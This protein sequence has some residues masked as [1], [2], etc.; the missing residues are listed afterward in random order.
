MK[1]FAI[2]V[3][4][5]VTLGFLG[6]EENGP[7]PGT[8]DEDTYIN[9]LVELQLF[10]AYLESTP[11]DSTKLDSLRGEIFAKYNVS[12]EVFRES[13]EYYQDQYI[14]QKERINKAMERLR[15]DQVRS[16]S[17]EAARSN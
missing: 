16:D 14:E 17:A 4:L 7:P 9:L 10:R 11:V 5:A 6:C 1:A 13:H 12:P 15:M 3:L 2:S 8:I